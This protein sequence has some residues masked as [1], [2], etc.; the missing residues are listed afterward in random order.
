M[1]RIRFI[2]VGKPHSRDYENLIESYRKRLLKYSDCQVVLIRESRLGDRP[3][4]QQMT[5]ALEEEG[6]SV[7]SALQKQEKM[8]LLD[9]RGK[10]YSTPEFASF[11]SELTSANSSLAFVVGSSYGVSDELRAKADYLW[12]LSDLTMTHPLALL[13]AMEQVY[14]GFKIARGETYS[15]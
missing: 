2:M 8:V 5:K 7:L 14:R 13:T 11:L 12:K 3:T 1:S 9:L 10:E 15:K 4:P 6:R